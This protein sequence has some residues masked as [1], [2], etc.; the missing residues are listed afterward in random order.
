MIFFQRE[1][2][3]SC[4]YQCILCWILVGVLNNLLRTRKI[5]L[6]KYQCLVRITHDKKTTLSVPMFSI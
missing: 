4:V 5:V 3:V 1:T 6:E 2:L